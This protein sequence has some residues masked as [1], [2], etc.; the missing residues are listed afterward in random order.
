MRQGGEDLRDRCWRHTA[1]QDSVQSNQGC[2]ALVGVTSSRFPRVEQVLQYKTVQQLY[3]NIVF[4][5]K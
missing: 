3:L 1:D 2:E 4:L 5:Q